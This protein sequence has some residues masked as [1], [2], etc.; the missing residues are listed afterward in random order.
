MSKH[1]LG[2]KCVKLWLTDRWRPGWT[3]TRT[4]RLYHTIIHPV[5]R[6]VYNKNNHCGLCWCWGHLFFTKVISLWKQLSHERVG[7]LCILTLQKILSQP[8]M[9][10]IFNLA[11]KKF[12]LMVVIFQD[13]K[14][15]LDSRQNHLLVD[16]RSHVEMEICKLPTDTISI[17]YN[18]VFVPVYC[19]WFGEMLS[20]H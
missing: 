13:Y 9:L 10:N 8:E 17:L 1:I 14:A 6:W 3:E 4:D 5:W 16:V 15:V 12:I 18:P 7:F 2:E 19:Q 11:I 20:N